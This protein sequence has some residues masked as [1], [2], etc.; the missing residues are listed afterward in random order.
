M[1]LWTVFWCC[2]FST[3]SMRLWQGYFRRV[4]PPWY[5]QLGLDPYLTAERAGVST[6]PGHFPK[7]SHNIDF[8]PLLRLKVW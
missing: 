6:A 7:P 1:W 3:R 5:L 2:C 8:A 4:P